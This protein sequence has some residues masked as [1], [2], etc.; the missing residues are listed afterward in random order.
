MDDEADIERVR[1]RS[2]RLGKLAIALGVLVLIAVGVTCYV[3]LAI[4]LSNSHD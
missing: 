3:L 2:L 1:R 4:A